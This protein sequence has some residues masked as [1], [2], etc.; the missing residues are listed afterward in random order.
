M[1]YK[2]EKLIRPL[3]YSNL[4]KEGEKSCLLVWVQCWIEHKVHPLVPLA[5]LEQ[6]SPVPGEK[7]R[8]HQQPSF[9]SCSPGSALV[10]L[11]CWWLILRMK[12]FHKGKL[13]M[14][15]GN[16]AIWAPEVIEFSGGAW[17]LA[18]LPTPGDVKYMDWTNL[19]G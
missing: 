3:I 19:T 8:G 11:Q 15:K 7:T 9:G 18:P 12:M 6:L 13:R 10:P 17:A 5:A 4:S 14:C 16:P 1:V 2:M